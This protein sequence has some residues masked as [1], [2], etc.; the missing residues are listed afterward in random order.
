MLFAERLYRDDDGRKIEGHYVY[1]DI[2]TFFKLIERDIFGGR[3]MVTKAPEQEEG[4]V[5]N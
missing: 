3:V 4:T 2:M 1:K 5:H